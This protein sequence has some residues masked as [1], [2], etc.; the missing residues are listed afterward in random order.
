MKNIILCGFMGSG[1]STVGKALASRL[2]REFI[3]MDDYI[4]SRE[5]MKIPAIFEKSGEEYFRKLEHEAVLE[6]AGISGL[7]VASGGGALTKPENVQAFQKN[8]VIVYLNAGFDVCYSRIASSDR[9]LVIKNSR[10][11]LERLYNERAAVY[12]RAASIEVEASGDPEKIAEAI[13]N[14]L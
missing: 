14:Q 4:E 8:C 11:Q 10:E 2:N 1:K 12:S 7:V 13:V 9:P 6:L 5:N 3:D